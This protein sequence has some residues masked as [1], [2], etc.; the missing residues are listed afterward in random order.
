MNVKLET[1]GCESQIS[2]M[3]V[4]WAKTGCGDDK[5]DKNKRL[6]WT[7]QR[8]LKVPPQIKQ[9]QS[10][11]ANGLLRYCWKNEKNKLTVML[12]SKVFRLG[13][14]EIR[15]D[16]D[17]RRWPPNEQ[18]PIQAATEPAVQSQPSSAILAAQRV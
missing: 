1:L 11:P 6:K 8:A 4:D 18:H 16:N 2:Q 17:D 9:G 10:A 7:L 12:T 3:Q 13:P 5:M 15:I 14:Q